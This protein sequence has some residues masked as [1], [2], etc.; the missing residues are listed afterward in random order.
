MKILAYRVH[1]HGDITL[2]ELLESLSNRSIADRI[3]E[4]KAT[5]MRLEDYRREGDN[6]FADFA[7]KRFGHGPGRLSDDQRIAEIELAPGESFGEDTGVLFHEPTNSLIVQYNHV[8]PRLTRIQ[9]YLHAAHLQADGRR[10]R[11]RGAGGQAYGFGFGAVLKPGA[12]QKIRDMGLV[13]EFEFEIAVPGVNRADLAAGRSLSGVLDAPLP[14]GIER[15][16]IS[17]VANS[18][19]DSHMDRGVVMGYINDLLAA[20]HI[21]Q[22]ANVKGREFDLAKTEDLSLLDEQLDIDLEVRVGAGGRSA[23]A[24]RWRALTTALDGWIENGDIV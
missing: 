19:R 11:P 16:K 20:R 5:G 9:H 10:R 13:R 18:S 4:G 8:G 1:Q 23:Q 17:M 14:D 7:I 21:V 22:S 15:L 6:Y 3:F 12:I 2:P 24:D